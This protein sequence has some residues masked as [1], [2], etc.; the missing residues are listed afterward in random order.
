MLQKPQPPFLLERVLPG[1][2]SCESHL[3]RKGPSG[4]TFEDPRELRDLF[5]EFGEVPRLLGQDFWLYR[6]LN[7]L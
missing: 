2:V 4:V 7:A 3:Y 1:A 5:H 6:G